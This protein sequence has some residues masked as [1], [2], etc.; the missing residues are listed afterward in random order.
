MDIAHSLN[1]YI[2]IYT[3]LSLMIRWRN[4]T[5]STSA[6]S[7]FY[8]AL[9]V[10]RGRI[11]LLQVGWAHFEPFWLWALFAG[12][13]FAVAL[14]LPDSQAIAAP[15]RVARESHCQEWGWNP[16]HGW[17]LLCLFYRWSLEKKTGLSCRI[18]FYFLLSSGEF[19]NT[20]K[21]WFRSVLCSYQSWL[22]KVPG[23][24]CQNRATFFGCQSNLPSALM[25]T[26]LS[27]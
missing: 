23:M 24:G 25:E 5:N 2:Y 26:V 1:T 6:L 20:P 10:F 12:Q 19:T 8:P 14:R 7:Y 21:A 27:F 3:L 11:A 13:P 4:Q 9:P 17:S 18:L 22:P 16:A 15:W